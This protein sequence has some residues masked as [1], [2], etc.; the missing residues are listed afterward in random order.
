MCN[1]WPLASPPHCAIICSLHF[2]SPWGVHHQPY[3]WS[4]PSPPSALQLYTTVPSV[5]TKPPH[6]SPFE[7]LHLCSSSLLQLYTTVP[8]VCSKL[9]HPSPFKH[10]H[11]WFCSGKLY[12][13][14]ENDLNMQTFLFIDSVLLDVLWGEISSK[15][16]WLLDILLAALPRTWLRVCAPS[17]ANIVD[18]HS[19][20][21]NPINCNSPATALSAK[22]LR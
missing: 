20:N 8:P 4:V 6:P 22:D 1:V 21:S 12:H 3:N 11:L 10:L 7:H 14:L 9:P 17:S 2:P 5:C 18:I 19:C 15:I 13:L 16:N